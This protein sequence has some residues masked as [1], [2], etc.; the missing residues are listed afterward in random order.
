M[1]VKKGFSLIE[2]VIV[3][4]VLGLVLPILFS[5]VFLIMQQQVRIYSLQEI[6]KQG[7]QAMLSMRS[8]MRQYAAIVADPT[9]IPYPTMTDICPVFPTPT[10]PPQNY[11]YLYDKDGFRFY[12][13]MSGTSIASNSADNG[14][15]D[16][17]LTNSN[18]SISG[19]Q[20]NCYRTNEFSPPIISVNYRVTK[21]GSDPNPP[22]LDYATR[23]QL[24]SY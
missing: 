13:G 15:V 16:Q 3:V 6:K 24:K 23:F 17:L 9:T 11:I 19:L 4:G 22:H 8:T 7:D 21:A 10:V 18:V 12:Y 20:F 14:I 1:G 2:M 5:I